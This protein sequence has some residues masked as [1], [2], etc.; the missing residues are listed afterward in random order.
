MTRTT[1]SSTGCRRCGACCAEGGPGLHGED[2]ALFLGQD[3]LP[4]SMLVAYR[5]GEPMRDQIKGIIA[6]LTREMLKIK[7]ASGS[8]A[9]LFYDGRSRSCGLYDRRPAEC[10]A[11]LCLDTSALAAMYDADRLTRADLLPTGHPLRDVLA[12]HDALTPPTRI[13]TLAE[14]FRAGGAAGQDALEELTRMV[15][16]DRAFRNALASRV[17]IDAEYH[18]FFLGRD[19]AALLAAHGLAL[20]DDAGTGFR[21]QTDPLWRAQGAAGTPIP[22][23]RI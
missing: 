9:C 21:I 17:G 2:A 3:A 4:L 7:S 11:L 20:R 15:L 5:R 1:D 13:A 6:P 12:E 8:R 18:D 23:R 14:A 10:R 19:M 16:A 22:R